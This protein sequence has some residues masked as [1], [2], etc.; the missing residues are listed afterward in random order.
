[1]TAAE[2]FSVAADTPVGSWQF[3]TKCDVEVGR[4]MPRNFRGI[5]VTT[6]HCGDTREIVEVYMCTNDTCHRGVRKGKKMKG[7]ETSFP[8]CFECGEA[9]IQHTTYRILPA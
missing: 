6:C 5:E 7:D 9:L 8:N 4:P 3:C 1:M 2:K